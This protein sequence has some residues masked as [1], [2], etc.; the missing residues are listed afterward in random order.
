M[1]S[2]FLF[3]LLLF[4]LPTAALPAQPPAA[5]ALAIPPAPYI[6]GPQDQISIQALDVQEFGDKPYRIDVDGFLRL[7]LIGRLKAAGLTVQQLE[8]Q[9]AQSLGRFVLKPDVSVSVVE[10]RSQPVSVIGSVRNPGIYQLQGSKTLVE[11][12]ALAGGLAGDAGYTVKITR[13][14]EHG[15]IPIANGALDATGA[16]YIAEVP[17]PQIMDASRPTE[18]IVVVADD[19]ISV[20]RAKLIYVVGQ[21]SRAGAFALQDREALSALKALTLAG[22]LSSSAAPHL[23]RILRPAPAG[24]ERAQIPVD[25]KKIMTGKASDIPLQPED[26][27]FVPVN[28]TKA[29]LAR[30]TEAAIAVSTG[31]IIYR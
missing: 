6:L 22:G 21:V 5:P 23:A 27:L 16:F 3:A 7:P 29:A 24:G 18:N 14:A 2:V 11:I 1:R 31:M 17:L 13:R 10:F 20:P 25:L 19:V 30:A 4:A 28:A 15:K 26:V 8:T 12:L 9:I